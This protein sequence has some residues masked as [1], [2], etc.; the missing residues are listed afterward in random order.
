MVS[1]VVGGVL[2]LSGVVGCGG[3]TEGAAKPTTRNID[4]IIVYNVCRDPGI[5]DEALRA[6]GLDP[7]TKS[8]FTDPPTG[9]SSF[10]ACRWHPLDDRFGPMNYVV[11]VYSTSHTLQEL[12][13]KESATVLGETT[14]NGRPGLISKERGNPDGCY[15]DF[16][17]EQGMFQVSVGW[18]S[19][20]KSRAGDTCEIAA[21]HAGLL[22][23]SLPK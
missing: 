20:Y 14:V 13:A 3:S 10:R 8:V 7:A 9:V 12:R 21:R 5:S 17:A 22:E 1:A 2:V 15:V 23:P 4:E 11:Y 18:L 19:E 6:A 16:N